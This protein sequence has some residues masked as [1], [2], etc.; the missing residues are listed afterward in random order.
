MRVQALAVSLLFFAAGAQAD[1]LL[2]IKMRLETTPAPP[3][4]AK[5][6]TEFE[7]QLWVGDHRVREDTTGIPISTIRR[8][9]RGK[10]Y[11]I[12]HRAKTYA[13]RDLPF[14]PSKE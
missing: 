11:I 9:D 8:F 10:L 2:T 14:D 1:T 6:P 12:D 5:V 13:E 3:P 7:M 4:T